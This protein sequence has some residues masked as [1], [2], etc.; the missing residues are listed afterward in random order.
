[1]C[2]AIVALERISLSQ[3]ATLLSIAGSDPSG[4]AGIQADLK[5]MTAIG[6]YGATA[7][8]CLTVQNSLGVQRVHALAPDLLRQQIQSA[9]TD[10][11]VSH[12]KIGMLGTL[13]IVKTVSNILCDYKGTVVYDPVLSAT[14]GE[15]LLLEASLELL[16]SKL[17]PHISYLTPNRHELEFLTGRAVIKEEE[18]VDCARFLLAEYPEMDGI[19]VKGGHFTADK[20][21]ICDILVL[22][23]GKLYK[24]KRD[25]IASSNLHGTG[26]TYSTAFSSYLL[27]GDTVEAAFRKTGEFMGEIIQAGVGV[28][29]ANSSTNG[30]LAHHLY[31][32]KP[33]KHIFDK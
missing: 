16:K 26:C 27:Q 5:T 29:I 32:R 6:V 24:S 11:F 13:E 2:E 22:Q 1:M 14:T 18:G 20:P 4:G 31:S 21:N 23:N 30:P 33:R 8:T 9:L 28:K 10:H 12:I 15:S 19:I 7:I 3:Q 25:R 17:C